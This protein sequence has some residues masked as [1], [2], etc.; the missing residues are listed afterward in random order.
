MRIRLLCVCLATGCSAVL[1]FEDFEGASAGGAANAAG[2]A[3]SG[4]ADAGTGGSNVAGTGAAAGSGGAAA[5][6]HDPAQLDRM[7]GVRVSNGE[8]VW[9][10]G[11]EVSNSEYAAFV[12]TITQPSAFQEPPC[13]WNADFQSGCGDD[14]AAPAPDAPVTCVDWC[15]AN[16]Y[17]SWA[18][19]TLC[20]DRAEP[21]E[22]PWQDVCSLNGEN[23]YPYGK[24]HDASLCAGGDN[25]TYGCL[26]GACALTPVGSHTGCKT[27][28][29]VL[30]LSGNAAEWVDECAS[31]VGPNDQCKVRGGSTAS[32]AGDLRC[33]VA[34]G[35]TRASRHQ[36]RGFRCCWQPR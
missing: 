2:T 4:T 27:L 33:D 18:N 20:G 21:G 17:C 15:D 7:V 3:A 9:I 31:Q 8:C 13:E 36:Y 34:A 29:G 28:S 32:S 26:S 10:D 6:C 16:A 25:P 30:D 24:S 1:G 23:E 14:A 35:A 11:R 19:K 5:E 22:S 12:S